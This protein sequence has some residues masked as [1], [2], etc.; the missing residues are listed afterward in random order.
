PSFWAS[1]ATSCLEARYAIEFASTGLIAQPGASIILP[2]INRRSK[3]SMA[4]VQSA[5]RF[6][7]RNYGPEDQ[8]LYLRG[9]QAYGLAAR[10]RITVLPRDQCRPKGTARSTDA[11][12]GDPRG[13]WTR[14]RHTARPQLQCQD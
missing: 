4:C 2:G 7:R 11:S 6:A 5:A 8:H 13:R 10:L 12:G 9:R 3:A 1:H 14:C